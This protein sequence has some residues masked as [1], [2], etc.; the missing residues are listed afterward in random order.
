MR[1]RDMCRHCLLESEQTCAL[2]TMFGQPDDEGVTG[3][4]S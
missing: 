3:A 4:A 2:Q 1:G